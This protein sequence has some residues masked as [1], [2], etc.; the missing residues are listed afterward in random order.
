[1]DHHLNSTPIHMRVSQVASHSGAS[2]GYD[3]RN[4]SASSSSESSSSHL[5]HLLGHQQR[6]PASLSF[7]EDSSASSLTVSRPPASASAR[8]PHRYH[9]YDRRADCFKTSSSAAE[10]AVEECVSDKHALALSPLPVL[11]SE[12]ARFACLLARVYF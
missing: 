10:K 3:S 2:S 1:M 12:S 11:P 7:N 6:R 5:R 8:N 4:A 9:T